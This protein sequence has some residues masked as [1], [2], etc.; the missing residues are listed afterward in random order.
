MTP[1]SEITALLQVVGFLYIFIQ[2]CGQ[3]GPNDKFTFH[4]IKSVHQ[5]PYVQGCCEMLH[6]LFVL[7]MSTSAWRV[8]DHHTLTQARIKTL[9]DRRRFALIGASIRSSFIPLKQ[10]YSVLLGGALWPEAAAWLPHICMH[11]GSV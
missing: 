8:T 2:A 9:Y 3:F 7:S 11:Y 6:Q 1:G 4:H 10:Y 5:N